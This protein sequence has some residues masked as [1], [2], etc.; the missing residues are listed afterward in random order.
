MF[1]IP[2]M[3]Q[4]VEHQFS[5][6]FKKDHHDQIKEFQPQLK[7]GKHGVRERIGTHI[8][9]IVFPHRFEFIVYPGVDKDSIREMISKIHHH[10]S[11][12]SEKV[13][14]DLYSRGKGSKHTLLLHGKELRVKFKKLQHRFTKFVSTKITNVKHL[15]LHMQ[16]ATGGSLFSTLIHQP[17]LRQYFMR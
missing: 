7:T 6:Q 5:R 13:K 8:E 11:T 14:V 3:K 9:V 10:M 12:I 15:V 4:M 1:P 17:N 2:E 16:N